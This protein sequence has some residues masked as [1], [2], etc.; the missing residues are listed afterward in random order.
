MGTIDSAIHRVLNRRMTTPKR[1]VVPQTIIDEL[2]NSLSPDDSRRLEQAT[3]VLR[4]LV[5]KVLPEGS[6][7]EDYER[8]VLEITN[9]IARRELER[10]LQ[11][12]ADRHGPVLRID[13]NN[14]WHGWRDETAHEYRRHLPG[15]VTYH[16]LVGG[17]IVRRYTYRE[18]YRNGGTYVPLELETGLMEHMTPG[19]ARYVALGFSQLPV[20]QVEAMLRASGRRPPSRSTLDRSARDV[21]AYAMAANDEIEP[22]VRAE[23]TV[24]EG[25]HAVVL[26]LDRAAVAMRNSDCS[27]VGDYVYRDLRR[28]RPKPTCQVRSAKGVSWRM[29][30]IATVAFVDADG[31][32]IDSR[33]YRLPGAADPALVVNRMMADVSHALEERPT[34]TVS[35]VQ[36]GAPELWKLLRSKLKAHPLIRDWHEVLDWYHVDERIGQCLD[37]YTSD[38]RQRAVQR[39]SWHQML[40]ERE[41]GAKT[42][43]RSLRRMATALEGDERA[44]LQV[45]IDFF[46]KRRS[47]LCYALTRRRGL[48]IGSGVTEGACKSLVGTRAK[49]SGQHWTQRGLTAALHLRS[50]EQSGRFDRYWSHFAARYRATS[51]SPA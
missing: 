18:C 34:L 20:R 16:S 4:E 8:A 2:A 40:L 39:A 29:D 6:S 12:I 28:P 27:H 11:A 22:L 37:L 44:A 17:L 5:E 32:R 50:I 36:D 47:L 7:F 49:R 25:T 21:G 41:D 35:I 3:R 9:E 48:P 26:G 10:K 1:P 23:E 15:K 31:D 14:D 43:L 45:H 13:H 38:P 33:Q 30:Y 24:P 19:L 46:A 51:I 42:F